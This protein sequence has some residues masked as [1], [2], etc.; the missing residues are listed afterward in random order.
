MVRMAQETG[1]I[2]RKTLEYF[3]LR[4]MGLEKNCAFKLSSGKDKF[5]VQ[6]VCQA[7]VKFKKWSLARPKLIKL[8]EKA[9]EAT[10]KMSPVEM[11][12]FNPKT[13]EVENIKQ[14]PSF[15]NR[16]AAAAMI[17]DRADPIIKKTE[18]LN[19][20]A[21]LA[22]PID[23]SAYLLRPGPVNITPS[24]ANQDPGPCPEVSL[25]GYDNSATRKDE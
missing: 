1:S 18:N 17:A 4:E 15:T 21:D 9:V 3:R 24:P 8:A 6:A 13:G 19:I 22:V 12:V 2:Q 7:E 16:L 14:Y 5:T 11:E 20:N 23:L 25:E 10:L